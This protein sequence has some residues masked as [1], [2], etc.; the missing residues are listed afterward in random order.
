[1]IAF[2]GWMSLE[3]GRN[4]GQYERAII[5]YSEAIRLN[6]QDSIAYYNR[7]LAYHHLEQDEQAIKDFDEAIRLGFYYM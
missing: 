3:R 2:A 7:G 4:L 5:D 1:M 6:P